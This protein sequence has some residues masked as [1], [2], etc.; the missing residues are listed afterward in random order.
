MTVN[1]LTDQW[2]LGQVNEWSFWEVQRWEFGNPG[3]ELLAAAGKE[4]F[5]LGVV[6]NLQTKQNI[7]ALFSRWCHGSFHPLIPSSWNVVGWRTIPTGHNGHGSVLI[8]ILCLSHAAKQT[9]PALGSLT[10]LSCWTQMWAELKKKFNKLFYTWNNY[11]LINVVLVYILV[12]NC[13][14]CS[15]PGI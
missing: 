3:S 7:Y 2:K 4:W 11:D 5:R 12:Q 9:P 8:T 10:T 14:F 6:R 13:S 1:I 15:Q